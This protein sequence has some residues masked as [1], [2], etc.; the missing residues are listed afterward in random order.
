[1]KH[2]LE[3]NDAV[4][5]TEESI[6]LI[7]KAEKE[8][9]LSV[10]SSTYKYLTYKDHGSFTHLCFYQED[11]ESSPTIGLV[12]GLHYEGINVLSIED[13]EKKLF[14]EKVT[15]YV[16]EGRTSVITYIDEEGVVVKF[17]KTV[18]LDKI[19]T[20]SVVKLKRTGQWCWG[21]WNENEPVYVVYWKTPHFIDNRFRVIK[22]DYHKSYATFIQDGKFILFSTDDCINFIKEVITY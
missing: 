11:G 14:G 13:F 10:H 16:P 18:D 2:N 20:G 7:S 6:A 17:N 5:I 19:T 1:M 3:L 4:L 8:R 12:K 15:I 22:K 21:D 9:E